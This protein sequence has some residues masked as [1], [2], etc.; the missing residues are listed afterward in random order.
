MISISEWEDKQYV[1]ESLGGEKSRRVRE[2][3]DNSVD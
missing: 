3:M 2:Q 1:S